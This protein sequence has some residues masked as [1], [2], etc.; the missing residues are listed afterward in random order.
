[1][2]RGLVNRI[3]IEDERQMMGLEGGT[4]AWARC[5]SGGG[6]SGPTAA[7][8]QESNIETGCTHRV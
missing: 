3:V 8:N 5:G 4:A 7:A 6:R 2:E 1:M